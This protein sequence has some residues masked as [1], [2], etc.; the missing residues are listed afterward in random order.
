MNPKF[1]FMHVIPIRRSANGWVL[2]VFK[3][4]AE[5]V[6]FSC[7]WTRVLGVFMLLGMGGSFGKV[8]DAVPIG[9]IVLYIVFALIMQPPATGEMASGYVG[10]GTSRIQPVFSTGTTGSPARPLDLVAL[11]QRLES[12]GRRV[13]KMENVVVTRERDWDRRLGT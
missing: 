3:G 9:A 6:G 12:L 5:H 1:K 2:G 8:G 13:A 10:T 7:T 4:F 11:E